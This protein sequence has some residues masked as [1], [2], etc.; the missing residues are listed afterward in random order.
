MSRPLD[1]VPL[2]RKE[3]QEWI[4]KYHRHSG[5]PVGDIIR[6]GLSVDGEI[7]GVAVAGRPV[8]RALDDGR[9]LEI[10]R[11]CT[12]GYENACSML[13]GAL[14]RAGK[15]LGFKVAITYTLASEPGSS[16][17]AS[18]FALDAELKPGKTWDTPSRPRATEK[19]STEAKRRWRREL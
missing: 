2:K 6:V 4:R 12:T 7:V 15:A 18:G 5:V 14:C 8:A 19:R 13:Y 9:T 11:V 10:T 16:V 3:A 17:K 1:L